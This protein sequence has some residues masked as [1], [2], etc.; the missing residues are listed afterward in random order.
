M[1]LIEGKLELG[2]GFQGQGFTAQIFEAING[3]IPIYISFEKTG[4]K[5]FEDIPIGIKGEIKGEI[6]AI[7]EAHYILKVQS[8]IENKISTKS[9]IFLNKIKGLNGIIIISWSGI[10]AKIECGVG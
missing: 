4:P 9:K 5:E 3:E 1:K 6:G 2:I 8:T 7:L 10:E